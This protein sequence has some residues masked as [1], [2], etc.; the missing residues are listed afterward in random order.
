MSSL[1]QLTIAMTQTGYHM[2]FN[3]NSSVLKEQI[4]LIRQG[5]AI[6]TIIT[7]LITGVLTYISYREL[8]DIRIIIWFIVFILTCLA[9]LIKQRISKH[10]I[11]SNPKKEARLEFCK[12]IL[13]NIIYCYLP[14]TFIDHNSSTTIILSI[15]IATGGLSCGAV[16]SLGPCW[17]VL[18]AYITPKMLALIFSLALLYDDNYH[19][20]IFASTLFLLGMLWFGKKTENTIIESIELRLKNDKLIKKLQSAL[21]QKDEAN[22]SKSMFLA[23]ASHDLRQPLHALALLGE[24]L[25]SMQLNKQQLEV[26]Q[27]MMSA[28]G[29]TR[30]MLD[31]FLDI[32]RLDAKAIVPSPKPFFIQTV[33][34]SYTHLTLPT[35]LL[36]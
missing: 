32:S 7:F 13:V 30:T 19:A 25:E 4:S 33:S 18:C 29:S 21:Q 24:S 20:L 36:V 26:Q 10:T 2:I 5:S 23:S 16:S 28:I 34:V 9:W 35:I 27:H 31:S 15:A 17:P 22:K 8:S 3:S 1:L 12:T 14:L 6:G 11:E